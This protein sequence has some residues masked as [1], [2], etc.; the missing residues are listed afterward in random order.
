MRFQ[1]KKKGGRHGETE[2]NTEPSGSP[3]GAAD[4]HSEGIETES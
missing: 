1:S 3:M 2:R 4:Q